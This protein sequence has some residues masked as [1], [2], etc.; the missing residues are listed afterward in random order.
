MDGSFTCGCEPGYSGPS[1]DEC[2]ETDECLVDPDICSSDGTCHN[3]IGSFECICNPGYYGNGFICKDD[4]ECQI[5]P[6]PACDNNAECVNDLGGYH[7]ACRSG[8]TSPNG[9]AFTGDCVPRNEC[10]EIFEIC[11]D[12]S[13]GGFCKDLAPEDSNGY[14][15]GCSAGYTYFP[16]INFCVDDNECEW[17]PCPDGASCINS[18]PGYSCECGGGYTTNGTLPPLG[19][20]SFF[21]NLLVENLCYYL[22][23]ILF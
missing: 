3:T 12:A 1:A 21:R 16:D 11:P 18:E 9:T 2:E 13:V 4:N 6:N 23:L 14:E 7:C 5:G 22:I 10:L 8:Y 19:N 20:L 15:C 17:S